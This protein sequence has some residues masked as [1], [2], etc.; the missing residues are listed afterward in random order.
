MK[1]IE[2]F[3]KTACMYTVAIL[4]F[5]YVFAVSSGFDQT[6]IGFGRFALILLFGAIIALAEYIF[7][8]K[9]SR[10]YTVLLHY[11][12]LLFA[13]I[14]VFIASGVLGTAGAKIFVSAIIFTVL[15]ALAFVAVYF[16]KRGIAKLDAKLDKKLPASKKPQ[17]TKA[18]SG[19]EPRFKN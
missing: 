8:I 12:I 5:F 19:Y 3:I 13:F 1:Q 14:I 17:S 6:A 16:G 15:Y 10:V 9:I 18:K 7:L 4:F 11:C 2:R